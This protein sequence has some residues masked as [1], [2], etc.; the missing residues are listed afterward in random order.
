[1]PRNH[2][3]L[4]FNPTTSLYLTKRLTTTLEVELFEIMQKS[5]LYAG[6]TSEPS[7]LWR[8]ISGAT[9]NIFHYRMLYWVYEVEKNIDETVIDLFYVLF[10]Y[11]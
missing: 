3:L 6:K 7:K 5:S 2:G 9:L 11:F 4:V 1:M 8:L 10:M